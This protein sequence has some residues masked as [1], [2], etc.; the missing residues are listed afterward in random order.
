MIILNL[1]RMTSSKTIITFL[2]F[3]LLLDS[4][5]GQ[6]SKDLISFDEFIKEANLAREI[7][8]K[9]ISDSKLIGSYD[10]ELDSRIGKNIFL[11]IAFTFSKGKLKKSK[12]EEILD[13]EDKLESVIGSFLGG[14]EQVSEISFNLHNSMVILPDNLL[15]KN[16]CD[17]RKYSKTVVGLYKKNLSGD[18]EEPSYY[19][20][21]KTD[22]IYIGYKKFNNGDFKELNNY[23]IP[24]FVLRKQ[25]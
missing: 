1:K 3:I 2:L 14:M 24:M 19:L 5:F 6:E 9:K 18:N 15:D 8:E 4:S 10:L 25:N 20:E 23:Y 22:D 12:V 16:C 13:Y 17:W 21:K 11:V 7:G